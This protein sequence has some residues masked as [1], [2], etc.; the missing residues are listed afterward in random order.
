MFLFRKEEGIHDFV[1]KRKEEGLR[2][3]FVPTMGALHDGHMSLIRK[4]REIADAV[5]AS[6]FV[7]PTQFDN[8]E[9]LL[10]YTR[11]VAADCRLLKAESCDAV[12]VP[13]VDEVYQEGKGLPV[14]IDLGTLG[15]VMEGKFRPGHFEGMMQVVRRLVEMVEPNDLVMGQKDFQQVAIV[16]R[17][18]HHIGRQDINLVVCPI[19]REAHGLAMSSRNERLDPA[20]R[21]G[22]KIIHET[23][24][25]AH[26]KAPD[27][28]FDGIMEEAMSVLNQ[29]PFKPI[30]FEIVDGHTLERLKNW[31]DADYIVACTAVWAGEVRLID[32]MILK[33]P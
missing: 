22:A 6:I 4:S 26:S 24:Q 17:M 20:L 2:V 13:D 29:E 3:A 18:L 19:R 27:T 25:M 21:Q 33:K 5:V 8:A 30:Y 31:E 11:S 10:K 32:N 14:D 7:N 28:D 15:K 12:F 1:Q 23:L 9:D 16:R